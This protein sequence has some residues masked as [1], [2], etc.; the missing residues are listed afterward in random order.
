MNYTEKYHQLKSLFN[1]DAIKTEFP[2]SEISCYRAS[3]ESEFRNPLPDEMHPHVF[4]S[5]VLSMVD[6]PAIPENH[7]FTYPVFMSSGS[8]ENG[9][10]IILL[11]G[12]NERSWNKYLVWAYYLTE[13]TGRPVIL[14]PIAFHMNR[15]PEAWSNPRA[16]SWLLAGRRNRYGEIPMS[17]FANLAL[18]ER[19][20][21]DPL[22]FFTSGQQSAADIVQLT[23]QLYGG[24]HPLFEKGTSVDFFAYSIGAFL[25]QI[26]LLGN[27][28]GLYTG[29]KFFLLCG[30]AMFDKM[31][32]VSKLIMDQKAFERLRHFYIEELDSELEK[33]EV[34]DDLMNQTP[35]GKG[36]LA[37]LSKTNLQQLRESSF[38]KMKNQ[39]QAV[40]LQK[41]KVISAEG[42]KDSLNKWVNVEVLDFPYNYTH[43]NPFPLLEGEKS[44]EVDRCFE[45]VFS[46]AAAFLK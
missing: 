5:G 15:S 42:I 31:D 33:S 45:T 40:A 36:F 2:D 12:L 37:M 23:K 32:G 10:A 21:E 14:F 18:S 16:M 46:R 9:R 3:F 22:R 17:T 24:E 28:D 34:L 25:A 1:P 39:I 38:Q 8:K 29:S 27:P 41:D 44:S 19:L 35:V 20:S 26:L 30:G 11:H 13:K 4:G 43:E 7:S 6:D